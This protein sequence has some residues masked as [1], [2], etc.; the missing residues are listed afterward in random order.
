LSWLVAWRQ[1]D[2][3]CEILS[4]GTASRDRRI[5]LP[6]HGKLGVSHAWIVDPAV[7]TIEVMRLEAPHWLLLATHG[8]DDVIRA[9]PFDAVPIELASLCAW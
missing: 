8:D 2:W 4:P 7:R 5:K 3:I 9:E 1:P 6:L